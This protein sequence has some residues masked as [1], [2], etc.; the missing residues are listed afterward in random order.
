MFGK[1]KKTVLCVRCKRDCRVAVMIFRDG[2]REWWCVG[3]LRD[4]T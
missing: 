1:R 4:I 3:C 2:K